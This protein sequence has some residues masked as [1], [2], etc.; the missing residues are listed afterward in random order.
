MSNKPASDHL[1]DYWDF[2]G[3]V[4][5]IDLRVMLYRDNKWIAIILNNSFDYNKNLFVI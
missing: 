2:G 3:K 5:V 4:L 1:T